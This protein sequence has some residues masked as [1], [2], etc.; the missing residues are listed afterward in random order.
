MGAVEKMKRR[1]DR[2]SAC[3]GIDLS[4]PA[5]VLD[6]RTR[7]AAMIEER[8]GKAGPTHD[9]VGEW[10]ALGLHRMTAVAIDVD[11]DL[12][13]GPMVAEPNPPVGEHD[14]QSNRGAH[15]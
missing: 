1:H 15:V 12:G 7:S 9:N 13:R 10:H 11:N 8:Y 5:S 2:A 14:R 4:K 6:R 3:H